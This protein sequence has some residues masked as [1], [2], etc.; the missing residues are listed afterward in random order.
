LSPD[1]E[2]QGKDL[3][4]AREAVPRASRIALLVPRGFWDGPSVRALREAVP[5]SGV[6]LVGATLGDPIQETEYRRAFAALTSDHVHAVIVGDYA[7]NFRH[8]RVIG[9]LAA[10]AQL[11][12]VA[13][14]KE[15]AEGGAL[16]AYGADLSV[17][18]RGAAGYVDRILR[19]SNRASYRTSCRRS[20][21]SSSI[22]RPR[23]PLA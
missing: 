6:T 10:Q 3:Q 22:R 18:Y 19:G 12:T 23:R 16:V 21:S 15:Y 13:P 4:L 14:N 5:R 7:E 20:S 11:P 17:S 8:I 2:I 9:A 1:A